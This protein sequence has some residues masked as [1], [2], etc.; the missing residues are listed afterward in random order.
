ML[1]EMSTLVY[2]NIVELLTWKKTVA[3]ENYK[4]GKMSYQSL[5]V[6]P[7]E[8]VKKI[9]RKLEN[10]IRSVTYNSFKSLK[11]L[12]LYDKPIEKKKTILETFFL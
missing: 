7:K 11:T 4:R 10:Y 5:S 1:K 2:P 9:I 3:R 12:R 6:P 8:N